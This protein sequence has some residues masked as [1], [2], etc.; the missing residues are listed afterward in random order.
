MKPKA[1]RKVWT[2]VYLRPDQDERLRALAK[3]TG[4]PL[5]FYMREG[6]D[7]ILA[8]HEKKPMSERG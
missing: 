4:A 3:R 6:A 7:L 8:K 1:D 5:T 2:R